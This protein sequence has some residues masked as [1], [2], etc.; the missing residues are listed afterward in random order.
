LQGHSAIFQGN[1]FTSGDPTLCGTYRSCSLRFA[2]ILPKRGAFQL[3][4]ERAR[5]GKKRRQDE[6]WEKQT[7]FHELWSSNAGGF[8]AEWWWGATDD[9]FVAFYPMRLL[10]KNKQTRGFAKIFFVT[11]LGSTGA[12]PCLRRDPFLGFL[13][14]A[15]KS[16]T[17]RD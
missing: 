5:R 17:D 16:F 9:G 3:R 2:N 6:E 1:D 10:E 15:V 13:Q 14:Q 11:F 4:T 12:L 8:Y 7:I